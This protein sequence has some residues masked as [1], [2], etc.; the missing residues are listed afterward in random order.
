MNAEQRDAQQINREQREV[1]S[2]ESHAEL[3]GAMT[4]QEF[5]VGLKRAS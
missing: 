3:R 2:V 1:E 4:I 5:S